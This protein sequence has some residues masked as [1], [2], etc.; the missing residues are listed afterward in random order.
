MM[1]ATAIT[2]P[3]E[4]KFDR[5]RRFR[6]DINEVIELEERL[7]SLGV[8]ASRMSFKVIRT[9]LYLGLRADDRKLTELR[10]GELMGSYLRGEGTIEELGTTI[11]KA[12]VNAGVLKDDDERAHADLTAAL[13]KLRAAGVVDDAVYQDV[14]RRSDEKCVQVPKGEEEEEEDD[15]GG[16]R[17]PSPSG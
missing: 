11:Q 10:V 3:V 12:L 1:A 6:L 8:L 5:T 13:G 7:G 16:A 2:K 9:V 14:F 15:A 4:L 17:P